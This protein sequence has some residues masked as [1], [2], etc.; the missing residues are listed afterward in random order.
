LRHPVK[1]KHVFGTW[2]KRGYKRSED[3]KKSVKKISKILPPKSSRC[4]P[5]GS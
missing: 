3:E 1:E 4:L 2:K 5:S